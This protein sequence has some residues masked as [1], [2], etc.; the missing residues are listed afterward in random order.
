MVDSGDLDVESFEG[1]HLVLVA[2]G[3]DSFEVITS[4]VKCANAFSTL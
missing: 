2:T 4:S 3:S 1:S